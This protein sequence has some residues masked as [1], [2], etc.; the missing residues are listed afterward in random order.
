MHIVLE[1]GKNEIKGYSKQLND[2]TK[3]MGIKCYINNIMLNE[4][5]TTVRLYVI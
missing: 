1:V 5:S 4:F 3:N 2:D